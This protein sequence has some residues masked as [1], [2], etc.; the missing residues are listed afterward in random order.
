MDF[1]FPFLTQIFIG[2]HT[3]LPH[4]SSGIHVDM[5]WIVEFS[6]LALG[7]LT[8]KEISYLGEFS[9]QEERTTAI[10]ISHDGVD[11]VV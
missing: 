7:T 2:S 3:S 11:V 1:L 6:G 4:A 10:I 9:W 5:N 8:M